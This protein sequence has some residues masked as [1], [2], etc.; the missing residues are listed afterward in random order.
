MTPLSG[1]QSL[2]NRSDLLLLSSHQEGTNNSSIFAYF[3]LKYSALQLLSLLT[4]ID[5]RVVKEAAPTVL[6]TA[7]A[8]ESLRVVDRSRTD[9]LLCT[10]V[11]DHC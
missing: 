5:C 9:I 3:K 2:I 8:E 1:Y 7:G 4:G 10:R 11:H 6:R